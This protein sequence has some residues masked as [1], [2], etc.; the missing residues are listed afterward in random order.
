LLLGGNE[1]VPYAR[2]IGLILFL[3]C[4]GYPLEHFAIADR[5]FKLSTAFIVGI[6]LSRAGLLYGVAF[7]APTLR[8]LLLAAAAQGIIQVA[9][10]L[11]YVGRS[12]AR[13][14]HLF[15]RRF[16][17]EQFVYVLPMAL[18]GL[19]YTLGSKI[20]S[21]ILAHQSTPA[22]FAIFSAGCFEVPFMGLV[23]EALGSVM[24]PRISELKFHG[25]L[26]E[27]RG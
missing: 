24:I 9:A 17:V 23:R 6:Q 8:N 5:Q 15:S 26:E 13:C 14:W 7:F 19:L 1:L 2:L 25:D 10:F 18:A 12:F 11:S 20:P 21:Y 22:K 27:V 4:L 3:Q 16:F